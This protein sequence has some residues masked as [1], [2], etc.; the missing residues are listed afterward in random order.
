MQQFTANFD[1]THPI[2]LSFVDTND[3]LEPVLASQNNRL[4][5]FQI[6]VTIIIVVIGQN[7][8]IVR[9]NIAI[10]HS[11]FRDKGKNPFFLRGH[12]TGKL[13][14]A[15]GLVSLKGYLLDQKPRPFAD[16]QRHNG[17]I[18]CF[19][20]NNGFDLS[21]HVT[22]LAVELSNLFHS[23]GNLRAI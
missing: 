3:N 23:F 6:D 16:I 4:I 8:D 14:I 22:L 17:L 20:G 11:T 9:E 5:D 10:Q 18:V 2:L 15:K 21:V 12:Q 19:D 7:R 13:A 1:L